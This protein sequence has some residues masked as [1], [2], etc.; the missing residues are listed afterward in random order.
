[1]TNTGAVVL[2]YWY[3]LSYTSTSSSIH[4]L[5]RWVICQSESSDALTSEVIEVSVTEQ[6]R[7][8]SPQKVERDLKVA[9]TE[10]LARIA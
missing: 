3:R 2:P 4:S 6:A 8:R 1:M 7:P 9:G 5:I 10:R